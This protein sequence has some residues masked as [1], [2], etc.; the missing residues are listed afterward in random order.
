MAIYTGLRTE[1]RQ[2]ATVFWREDHAKELADLGGNRMGIQALVL[3]Q[4]GIWVE[5]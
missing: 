5:L 4:C 2:Q 1:D 3:G